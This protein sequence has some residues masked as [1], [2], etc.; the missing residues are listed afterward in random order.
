M[1][2]A[3]PLSHIRKKGGVHMVDVSRK[4][5]TARA[6]VATGRVILGEDV[7]DRLSEGTV[8]K[9]DVFSVAQVAGILGAKRTSTLIPLC[10]QVSVKGVDVALSLDENDRAVDI[11]A[12]ARSVGPTG[13]EMEAL[14]AVTV[15]ALTVYDMCKSLSKAIRITDVELVSKSG[16]KS[17]NYHTS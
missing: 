4:V 2:E 10:H 14:V 15:A 11:R 6:A 8:E 12:S 9:G 13:V 1:T 7:Y 16:G 17:G 5:N 3:Q